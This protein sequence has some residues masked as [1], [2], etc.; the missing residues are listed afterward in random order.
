MKPLREFFESLPYR[1]LLLLES[2]KER[3]RKY[4]LR[5]LYLACVRR[6]GYLFLWLGLRKD[7]LVDE[8]T[9]Y[10]EIIKIPFTQGFSVRKY[11]F[12]EGQEMF[13]TNFITEVLNE[14]NVFIDGGA[15][16][17][18]YTVLASHIV[19]NTGRVYSFEPTPG[20]YAI[21]KENQK[22][23]PNITLENYALWDKKEE[24]EFHDFGN[25]Y[26]VASTALSP[27]LIEYGDFL[28]SRRE[29][30]KIIA[31][32]LTLD[33]YCAS[34]NIYP[35]FIKLDTEGSELRIVRGALRTIE[36]SKP[37]ISVEV[38]RYALMQ[39]EVEEM[40]RLLTPLGYEP[41]VLTSDFMIMPYVVPSQSSRHELS[42]LLF[43]PP[44]HSLHK[45]L[46]GV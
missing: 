2:R 45:H 3:L 13:L 15:A 17:G 14:G 33:D 39:G 36:K 8:K 29:Y 20:F 26:G 16:F 38:L 6:I 25:R 40:L 43:I 30:R 19:G 4:P 28:T 5:T 37:Y 9:F 1:D 32:T 46:M 21:L 12:Y 44:T 18:W 24:I 27:S 10:E 35:D 11:G 31:K 41:Y 22:G 34:H 42:N 7:D 23:R